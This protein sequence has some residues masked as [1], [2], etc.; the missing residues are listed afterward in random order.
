VFITHPFRVFLFQMRSRI[1]DITDRPF[2]ARVSS[3]KIARADRTTAYGRLTAG[4]L[5]VG[6]SSLVLVSVPQRANGAPPDTSPSSLAGANDVGL[7]GLPVA[8][9]AASGE[10]ASPG[11][12]VP[13]EMHTPRPVAAPTGAGAAPAVTD[14]AVESAVSRVIPPKSAFQRP[15]DA[16]DRADPVGG[17]GTPTP[18]IEAREA[19]T[20]S[21]AEAPSLAPAPNGADSA[22]R[23]ALTPRPVERA[24][25]ATTTREPTVTHEQAPRYHRLAAQYRLESVARNHAAPNSVKISTKA[26]K[27]VRVRVRRIGGRIC[28]L[29]PCG[30]VLADT[31][32]QRHERPD[33][34]APAPMATAPIAN[35]LDGIGDESGCGNTNISVR[36]SSPGDD[37]AVAQAAA[38]G[39]CGR[40]TNI[41]IRINSPGDNGSVSQ[42]IRPLVPPGL[43]A[44]LGTRLHTRPLLDPASTGP[45]LPAVAADPTKLPGQLDR[46]ARRLANSLVARAQVKA[47]LRPAHSSRRS[48]GAGANNRRRPTAA[49]RATAVAEVH[50]SAAGV[51]VAASASARTAT[52]REGRHVRPA[53]KRRAAKAAHAPPALSVPRLNRVVRR[54]AIGLPH[55]D[56]S[57]GSGLGLEAMLVA[58]AA[59]LAGAYLIVPPAPSRR[60]LAA[61]AARSKRGLRRG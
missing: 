21:G 30:S 15:L 23:V 55:V 13:A 18:D 37:G 49:P 31:P 2:R 12:A 8:A 17:G 59:A 35:L 4:L 3:A 22:E 25:P 53:P 51:H 19:P 36:I 14:T 41:S 48:A 43:A 33:T 46:S 44:G 58:F 42:S 24:A 52:P 5:A 61:V 47:G 1:A 10:I 20:T 11:P 28:V 34:S 45:Q 57:R 27:N 6:V 39:D 56:H 29:N 38:G 16:A 7:A 32:G 54:A 60:R 9:G 40:N 26:P 50:V